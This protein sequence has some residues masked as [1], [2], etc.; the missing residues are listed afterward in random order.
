MSGVIM[1]EPDSLGLGVDDLFRISPFLYDRMVASLVLTDEDRVELID[2]F[3]VNKMPSYPR[4]AARL[5]VIVPALQNLLPV[6]WSLRA[7]S[8]ITLPAS[9]PEPDIAVVRGSWRTY[10]G[11]HPRPAEIGLVIEIADNSIR[12]YR[13]GR[14]AIYAEA[15]LPVYWIVN[16]ADRVVEVYTRPNAA[17]RRYEERVDVPAGESV[18]LIL[19]GVEVA[20]LPLSEFMP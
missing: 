14:L 4:H 13:V 1:S 6:G 16:S 5:Q 3:L 15:G 17:E 12:Y 11:H 7:K 20:R 9:A 2:G 19:D 8:E 18:P 10:F